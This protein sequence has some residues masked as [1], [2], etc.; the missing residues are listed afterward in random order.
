MR[1]PNVRG[2]VRRIDPKLQLMATGSTRHNVIRAEHAAALRALSDAQVGT[3]PAVRGDRVRLT[4]AAGLDER[5]TV[6]ARG[7]PTV[8]EVEVSVFVRLRDAAASPVITDSTVAAR[9]G[10]A[11]TARRDDQLTAEL[12]LDQVAALERR[13]EVAYIEPGQPLSAPTPDRS[14]DRS[15]AP[16]STERAFGDADVH[17]Y[18]ED[19]LIGIIDVEGFDFSHPEF[20]DDHGTRFARIWDQA[21]TARVSP[22]VR[23]GASAPGIQDYGAEFH[24]PELDAALAAI[25]RTNARPPR[26][27]A[28]STRNSVRF[29]APSFAPDDAFLFGPETRGLPDDVLEAIP[30]SQR[31][32]LPMREGNRS[33]NLSN[34]V[35]V[36]VFEAWRQQGFTG[37][38]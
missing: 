18:G 34:A 19:V 21:G 38:A 1:P 8:P 31:L 33:L 23:R 16:P 15:T 5:D 11:V 12:T 3:T 6:H 10:R 27:F 7:A 37:A 35:A 20:V 13:P 9:S 26:L 22:A 29:D 25:T 30:P 14:V 17:G 4:T 28:L 24:K 2:S 32:R 36:V